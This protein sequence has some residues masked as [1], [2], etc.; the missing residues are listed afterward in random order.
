[1]IFLPREII[2]VF[3]FVSHY[4]YL[5]M[6]VCGD[7]ISECREYVMRAIFPLDAFLYHCYS[8]SSA[9]STVP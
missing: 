1:M 2:E 9:S 4:T 3:S 5:Y 8:P 6:C 7:I